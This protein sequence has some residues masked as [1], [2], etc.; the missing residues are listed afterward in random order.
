MRLIRSEIPIRCSYRNE[1]K[2]S[3][4]SGLVLM[5]MSTL[6]TDMLEGYMTYIHYNVK[7]RIKLTLVVRRCVDQR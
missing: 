3:E 1:I 2:V 5:Y 4:M 7:P 6:K